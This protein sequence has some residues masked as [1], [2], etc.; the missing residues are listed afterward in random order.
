MDI[1]L[2]GPLGWRK[3]I[4]RLFEERLGKNATVD[5]TLYFE[6]PNQQDSPK[7]YEKKILEVL[8]TQQ[9]DLIV[10]CSYGVNYFIN[11]VNQLN[12]A[13]ACDQIILID[14]ILDVEPE[15]II[16]QLEQTRKDT[17]STPKQH[18]QA[19]L[20]ECYSQ[21]EFDIVTSV[22]D[23]QRN[24]PVF[25]NREMAKWIR[26]VP[27]SFSYDAIKEALGSCRGIT[28]LSSD[29]TWSTIAADIPFELIAAEDH[30]LMVSKP[31]VIINQM[32]RIDGSCTG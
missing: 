2:F 19:N 16:A 17:F 1:C 28:I 23:F 10:A 29:D 11:C 20:G 15:H 25:S 3:N 30:L 9:F 13:L 14:G 24:R 27:G 21:F 22:Y 5:T 31:E 18:I 4:W 6:F 32:N 8:K 7:T 26:S 12:G